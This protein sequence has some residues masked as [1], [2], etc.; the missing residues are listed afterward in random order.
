MSEG[1]NQL[2]K[3][4]GEAI[5]TVPELYQ[6]ALQPTVQETGKFL[7]RIPRAINAAFAGLDKWI[8]NKEYNIDETKKLLA[9][10][11]ENIDPD[12]IVVPEPY[13]AIPA[14]QAISYSMNSEEL[15]NLYANLLASS[16]KSDTK[17]LVHPSFIEI[18][19]QMSPIDAKIFKILAERNVNPCI[20]LQ[21]EN[22]E[23]SFK[24]IMTNVTDLLIAPMQSICLVIDNLKKQNLI[25]IPE[26]GYYTDDT[27]YNSII[28]SDFYEFQKKLY[29]PTSDGFKFTYSKKQINI[30]NLG[31]S[32]Y[33]L[34]VLECN[35]VKPIK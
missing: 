6:D 13:V 26:D 28:Q 17:D 3:G 18:I 15:R 35:P 27:L 5:Q 9:Q 12:K 29:P 23:G 25:E 1:L 34:C 19:K 24:T 10:K 14:L 31:T 30:T 16:M 11:L 2:A 21:Y 8:L 20:N 22:E 4:I 33:D 7:A 32:F